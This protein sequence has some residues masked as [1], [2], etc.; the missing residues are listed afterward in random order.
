MVNVMTWKLYST[1]CYVF[2]ECRIPKNVR[3]TAK[4]L[5]KQGKTGLCKYR[6]CHKHF[7]GFI[8]DDVEGSCLYESIHFFQQI[9]IF[10]GALHSFGGK[11]LQENHKKKI[12]IGWFWCVYHFPLRTDYLFFLLSFGERKYFWV[13]FITSL[14]MYIFLF[15]VWIYFPKL[16]SAPL[17]RKTEQ[18]KTEQNKTFKGLQ[19]LA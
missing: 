11:N 18:N 5:V 12:C 10:K 13:C 17:R 14:I 8:S 7:Y 6:Q 16:H 1:I 19:P 3:N 2:A 15:W 9:S 4:Y